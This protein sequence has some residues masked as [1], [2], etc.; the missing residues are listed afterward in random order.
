MNVVGHW[1]TTALP[2]ILALAEEMV[3]T[4]QKQLLHVQFNT[5]DYDTD[6]C[7]LKPELFVPIFKCC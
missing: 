4:C 6:S 2:F 7:V 5:Y 1:S 3:T